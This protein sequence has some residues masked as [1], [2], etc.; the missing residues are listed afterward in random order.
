MRITAIL[1]LHM[2]QDKGACGYMGSAQVH[3]CKLHDL[4]KLPDLLQW[5]HTKIRIGDLNS[6]SAG[7]AAGTTNPGRSYWD[8][9]GCG[10]R[11]PCEM[12]DCFQMGPWEHRDALQG[13]TSPCKWVTHHPSF[14]PCSCPQYG[15]RLLAVV[16]CDLEVAGT[17]CSAVGALLS[18]ANWLQQ[19]SHF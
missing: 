3:L 13:V 14:C 9:G 12:A 19:G 11:M 8:E 2:K 5:L 10:L 1:C 6:H 4:C 15:V 7:N 16:G 17:V 18:F